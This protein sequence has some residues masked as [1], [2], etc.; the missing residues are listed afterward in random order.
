LDLDVDVL[1][2]EGPKFRL[3]LF[4]YLNVREAKSVNMIQTERK[5]SIDC[6]AVH[7]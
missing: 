3:E 4:V 2:V 7:H 5:Y 1:P 6:L